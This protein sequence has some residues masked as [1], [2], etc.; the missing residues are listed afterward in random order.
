MPRQKMSISSRRKTGQQGHRG[1]IDGGFLLGGRTE[2]HPIIAA[3]LRRDFPTIRRGIATLLV[4]GAASGAAQDAEVSKSAGSAVGEVG[5]ARARY[6]VALR[7]GGQVDAGPGLT[8]RGMTPNDLA[9]WGGFFPG[10]GYFGGQL[11]IQREGFALF[12]DANARVT[13]GALLRAS[14][15]PSA[16]LAFG[17]LKV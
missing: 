9:L 8:Y 7:S 3:A 4:L 17:A 13:G 1:P 15:G 2:S 5:F 10:G 14:A 16:R 11:S 6:G 12:D